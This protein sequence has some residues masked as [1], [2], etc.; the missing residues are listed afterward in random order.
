MFNDVSDYD[1]FERFNY[2][3]VNSYNTNFFLNFFSNL[4]FKWYGFN[5]YK[6]IFWPLDLKY[7]TNILFEKFK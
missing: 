2:G 5:E 1:I 3:V 6:V 7:S 4:A